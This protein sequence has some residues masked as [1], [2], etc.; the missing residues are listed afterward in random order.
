M[1]I[2]FLMKMMIFFFFVASIKLI[3][4]EEEKQSASYET[5]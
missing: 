2:D 5:E 3:G 1:R 4:F